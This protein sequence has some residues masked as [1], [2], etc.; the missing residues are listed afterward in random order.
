MLELR[1]I[2]C[3]VAAVNDD[4]MKRVLPAVAKTLGYLRLNYVVIEGDLT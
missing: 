4:P 2:G 1:T 3:S